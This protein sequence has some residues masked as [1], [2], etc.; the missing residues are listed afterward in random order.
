MW[1]KINDSN[2]LEKGK[3]LRRVKYVIDGATIYSGE[4][5]ITEVHSHFV[6]FS[7]HN[8]TPISLLLTDYEIYIE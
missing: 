2:I 7:D 4:F 1:A 3:K 5:I 8:L 6:K